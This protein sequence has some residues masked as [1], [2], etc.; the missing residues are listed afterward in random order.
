MGACSF[1]VM[2][3]GSWGF[4]GEAVTPP[5]DADIVYPSHLL[6]IYLRLSAGQMT[7]TWSVPGLATSWLCLGLRSLRGSWRLP[8]D[9]WKEARLEAD[10]AG[11]QQEAWWHGLA[12][13]L[14]RPGS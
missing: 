13:L 1:C 8:T 3:C 9:F 14:A 4:V 6:G 2:L 11:C 12:R 5:W 10:R 7:S